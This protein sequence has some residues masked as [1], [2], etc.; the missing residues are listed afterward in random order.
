MRNVAQNATS[1]SLSFDALDNAGQPVVLD[2]DSPDLEISVKSSVNGQPAYT[3]LTLVARSDP[4]EWGPAGA[5]KNIGG[6][7]EHLID[8]PNSIFT[9]PAGVITLRIVSPDVYCAPAESLV[10]DNKQVLTDG[11]TDAGR[12]AFRSAMTGRTI[13]VVSPLFVTPDGTPNFTVCAGDDHA[14][15]DSREL[16]FPPFV[17]IETDWTGAT[18]TIEFGDGTTFDATIVNETGDSREIYFELDSDD[19]TALSALTEEDS[20]YGILFDLVVTLASGNRT[21]MVKDGVLIVKPAL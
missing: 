4:D 2:H 6:T 13:N 11:F 19:T 9:I 15:A 5:I 18:A 3:A 7:A 17:G 1:Q 8:I 14:E 10:I 16:R 12:S 21:H 20:D